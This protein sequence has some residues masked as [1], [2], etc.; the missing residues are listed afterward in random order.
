MR[1]PPLRVPPP[2]LG[3]GGSCIKLHAPQL[4]HRGAVP[5]KISTATIIFLEITTVAQGWSSNKA[6]RSDFRNQQFEPDTMRK[7][8]RSLSP[9][10]R[11]DSTD[12]ENVEIADMKTRKMRLIG[13]K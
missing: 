11:G 2:L 3:M 7:Y 10:I 12:A 9:R 5:V 4:T 13:L 6:G 8:V 1:P